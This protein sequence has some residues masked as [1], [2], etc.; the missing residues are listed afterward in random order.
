VRL[1]VE[2]LRLMSVISGR[3]D[4]QEQLAS[5]DAGQ[6]LKTVRAQLHKAV[7]AAQQG[8]GSALGQYSTEDVLAVLESSGK[9]SGEKCVIQ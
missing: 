9:Y 7:K 3:V 5:G 6:T 1:Q 4:F 8:S 2:V